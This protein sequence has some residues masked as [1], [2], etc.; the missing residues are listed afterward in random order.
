MLKTKLVISITIFTFLLIATSVIKNKTRVIEKQILNFSNKILL[1]KKYVNE[2]QLEFY[3]LTSPKEIEYRLNMI[4]FNNYYPIS[5]SKIFLNI[6]D[7]TNIQNKISNLK[8]LNEKK[9]KAK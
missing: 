6:S 7:F 5:Y 8:N 2:A 3:Y 4:G 1:K 9:I